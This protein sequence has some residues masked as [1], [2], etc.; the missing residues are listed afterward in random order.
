MDDLSDR[1]SQLLTTLDADSE[2]ARIIRSL[3]N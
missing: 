3:L 1:L 2:E